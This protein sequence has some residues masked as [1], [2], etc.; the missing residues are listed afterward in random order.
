VVEP[1]IRLDRESVG[2][3]G[4][5]RTGLAWRGGGIL[6][7]ADVEKSR[8]TRARLHAGLEFTPHPLFALRAGMD[9]RTLTAGAGIR[10]AGRGFDY[11]FENPELGPVHRLGV[12]FPFGRT[13][14]ESRQAAERAE[15]E[16]LQTRL[17]EAF[18]KQEHERVQALLARAETA[19][20]LAHFDEAFEV[21]ATVLTLEPDQPE[22][23]ALD[24][25]C[26]RENAATLETSGEFT[27][28][29]AAYARMLTRFPAD[30][31][32]VAAETRC[33]DQSDRRA[34][35]TQSLR[36]QFALAMDAFGGDDLAAARQGF[37][38][39]LRSAPA[40]TDAAAMLRRTEVAI[41]R[42]ADNLLREAR[43][44]L[45][46][47][48]LE[49]AGGLI[50]QVA[51]LDRH[52]DGL[53]QAAAALTQ[54]RGNATVRPADPATLAPAVGAGG[55][56]VARPASGS[57]NAREVDDLNRRALTAMKEK[58]SDDALRYWELVWSAD[59]GY[60]R[61]VD[62]L[63]REY[64]MRGLEAFAAGRLDDAVGYWEKALQ[65]DPNDERARGYL[66]RALKQ[67][68]RTQEI[69]GAAR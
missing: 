15:G 32:A 6:A 54:A 22:A 66:A 10:W 34:A 36:R 58:R 67:R 13:V 29:A 40:D 7:T 8:D 14:L 45:A 48:R 18:Q 28:A 19:R 63:K 41:A 42:R 11:V 24:A 25:R 49:E 5:L 44:S 53:P 1:A 23:L 52:A 30:T 46:A 47:G 3:P 16:M 59:P 27:A 17:A 20:A 39:V 69:L 33:R 55:S 35:R 57:R 4:T 21:L 60:P 56:A 43:R 64:L 50:E 26:Q 38:A 68:A 31:A 2:D 62:Y 9:G 37:A 51:T 61:V 65:V 12:S